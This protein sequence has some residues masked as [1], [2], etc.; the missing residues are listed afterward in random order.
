MKKEVIILKGLILKD[1]MCLK[2]Q[3]KQ[4]VFLVIGVLIVSVMYVLSANREHEDERI[5]Q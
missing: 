4:F 2:K 3:L 1:L 5:G